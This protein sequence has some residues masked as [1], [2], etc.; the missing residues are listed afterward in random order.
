MIDPRV[1]WVRDPFIGMGLIL[2][3]LAET[4]KKLSEV[5]A[6][7]PAY[8]IVKDK[9]TVDRD[10]LPG[11]FAAWKRALAGGEG[12]PPGR[13]ATGLGGPLDSRAA[14]QHRADRARHRGARQAAAAEGLCRRGW[15]TIAIEKHGI[16]VSRNASRANRYGEVMRTFVKVLVLSCTLS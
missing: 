6:E 16:Y 10:K 5:V 4:G 14:E 3:L 7:L 8:H 11:L 12:Q 2:N 9:Y 15:R 1:G 13:A